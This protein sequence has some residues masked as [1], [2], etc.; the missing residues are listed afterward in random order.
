MNNPAA[1]VGRTEVSGNRG[2]GDWVDAAAGC[3]ATCVNSSDLA[4]CRF[5]P[6][7]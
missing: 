4:E 1:G 3:K 2:E 6:Q 7:G 5:V